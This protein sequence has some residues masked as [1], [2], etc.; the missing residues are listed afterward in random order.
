MKGAQGT[1]DLTPVS[2]ALTGR[3]LRWSRAQGAGNLSY[4][5][6]SSLNH[7]LTVPIHST[8]QPLAK[9]L[10]RTGDNYLCPER[11]RDEQESEHRGKNKK[12]DPDGRSASRV[13]GGACS[14]GRSDPGFTST[15]SPRNTTS[16]SRAFFGP[17]ASNSRTRKVQWRATLW[18]GRRGKKNGN[19]NIL[20]S[21]LG[22]SPLETPPLLP[23]PPYIPLHTQ[24]MECR[25]EGP[26]SQHSSDLTT[27]V[28]APQ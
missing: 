10:G 22:G 8:F 23:T 11:E 13:T 17:K 5:I 28:P 4:F 16:S 2:G 14:T 3:L 19:E 1:W 7:H 12:S 26:A 20:V 15:F 24:I 6:F 27:E 25:T 18:Q 21:W 9:G